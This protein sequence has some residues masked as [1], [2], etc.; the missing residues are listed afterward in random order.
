MYFIVKNSEENIAH[1]NTI[2]KSEEY[3]YGIVVLSGIN[4][5]NNGLTYEKETF[6]SPHFRYFDILI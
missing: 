6:N 5:R 2:L 3:V 4:C 1:R